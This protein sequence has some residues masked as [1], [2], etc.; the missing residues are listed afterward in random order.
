[1]PSFPIRIP[2]DGPISI[3]H[4]LKASI[5]RRS[6]V[7]AMPAERQR[8][9]ESGYAG[10]LRLWREIFGSMSWKDSRIE[11]GRKDSNR[12]QS[13]AATSLASAQRFAPEYPLY[14]LL[15]RAEDKNKDVVGLPVSSVAE[16]LDCLG[17]RQKQV[18]W[19][20]RSMGKRK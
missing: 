19:T 6:W 14:R 10:A 5:H 18:V 9:E 17:A 4:Q 7:G 2:H 20:S 11:R 1:M 3:Q 8:L 12:R 15:P 13:L 16:R